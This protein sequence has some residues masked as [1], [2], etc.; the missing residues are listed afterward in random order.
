MSVSAAEEPLAGQQLVEDDAQ[1]EEVAAPVDGLGPGLLG[2]H[3]LEL[4]LERAGLRLRGLRRGLRDAE[5]AELDVALVG[6]QDVLGRHVAMHDVQIVALG[7]AAAVRV[8]ERRGHLGGDVDRQRNRQRNAQLAGRLL[9]RAQVAAVDVLHRDEVAA[10]LDL[11]EVVDVDD[12]RVVQLGRELGLVGEHRDELFV[13]GQVR[14]DLLDRDDLLESFH[15][16]SLGLVELGHAA[17]GDPFQDLVLAEAVGARRRD[18]GRGLLAAARRLRRNRPARRRR[19]PGRR[20]T[21]MRPGLGQREPGE[22]V[23]EDLV[24]VG[25]ARQLGSRRRGGGRRRRGR[26]GTPLGS[27][28]QSGQRVAQAL[29]DVIGGPRRR[30]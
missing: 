28:I 27:E 26:A 18:R 3:V 19:H 6:D 7:V 13:V 11:P 5:V 8:V 12:V 16:R 20:H 10:G 21:G 30:A 15:A 2:R 29:L 14:K 24:D 9:N 22:R 17:A 1:R 4:P 25:V 23:R